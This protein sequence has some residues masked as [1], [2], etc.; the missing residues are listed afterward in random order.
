MIDVL[1]F[2]FI[3]ELLSLESSRPLHTPDL[4]FLETSPSS[5]S[6]SIFMKLSLTVC[7]YLVCMMIFFQSSHLF[8]KPNTSVNPVYQ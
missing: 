4:V 5:C 7:V 8:E 2:K 3:G 1:I 6:H